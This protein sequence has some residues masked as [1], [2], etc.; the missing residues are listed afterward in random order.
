M[1]S[2]CVDA[3]KKKMDNHSSRERDQLVS[4]DLL[5]H[6][7]PFLKKEN[8]NKSIYVKDKYMLLIGETASVK[9]TRIIFMVFEQKKPTVANYENLGTINQDVKITIAYCHTGCPKK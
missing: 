7:C 6:C 9:G 1:T 4:V 2:R 3:I 8:Q 5:H